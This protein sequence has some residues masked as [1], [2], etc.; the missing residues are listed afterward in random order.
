MSAWR[1]WLTRSQAACHLATAV[2][3][4]HTPLW[5]ATC[6]HARVQ[7]P[8]IPPGLR[9]RGVPPARCGAHDSQTLAPLARAPR[10]QRT[11]K[12]HV[13]A[14]AMDAADTEGW[15]VQ[16]GEARLFLSVGGYMGQG[17]ACFTHAHVGLPCARP[18]WSSCSSL[19]RRLERSWQHGR[20]R[21]GLTTSRS[22]RDRTRSRG[23][24]GLRKS[25]DHLETEN[26]R[27][28]SRGWVERVLTHTQC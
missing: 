25:V 20:F 11:A 14:A 21:C 9:L 22:D 15:V 28:P 26:G 8:A 16:G 5:I 7:S 17:A 3:R 24:W 23:R 19:R 10:Q 13:S 2:M 6:S 1:R 18:P 4:G 12:G 27:R